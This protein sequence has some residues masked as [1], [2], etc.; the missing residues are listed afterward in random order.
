MQQ[1]MM[2][3][4]IPAHLFWLTKR[5]AL[6]PIGFLPP[7]K[8][9]K[10]DFDPVKNWY[11]I[12]NAHEFWSATRTMDLTR[13]SKL[14]HSGLHQQALKWVE[15]VSVSGR[16]GLLEHPLIYPLI[17]KYSYGKVLLKKIYGWFF[18]KNGWFSFSLTTCTI[19]I[20]FTLFHFRLFDYRCMLDFPSPYRQAHL[21][22]GKP[23][24]PEVVSH[25]RQRHLQFDP[26]MAHESPGDGALWPMARCGRLNN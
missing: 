15:H 5:T 17:L 24:F 25:E 10:W 9:R 8:S 16:R 13:I 7:N 11:F 23:W 19:F 21:P 1:V 18:S 12:P 22:R 20:S 6:G 4:G 26:P 2:I 14:K 3:D